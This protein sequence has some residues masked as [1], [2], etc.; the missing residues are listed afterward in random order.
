MGGGGLLDATAH[1][2]G[3]RARTTHPALAAKTDSQLIEMSAFGSLRV[4]ARLTTPTQCPVHRSAPRYSARVGHIDTR[5]QPDV[6]SA[7]RSETPTRLRGLSVSMLPANV[8]P[9]LERTVFALFC[10][11]R[12]VTTPSDRMLLQHFTGLQRTTPRRRNGYP[13]RNRAGNSAGAGNQRVG[14]FWAEFLGAESNPHG[15]SRTLKTFCRNGERGRS[16]GKGS[17]R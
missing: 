12:T 8:V 13:E 10:K 4:P 1:R 9:R 3:P 7:L 2:A 5:K 11:Q 17:K 16:G 15:L 6:A 14:E